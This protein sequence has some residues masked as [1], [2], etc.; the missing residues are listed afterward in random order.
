M[1]EKMTK[2]GRSVNSGR[3]SLTKKLD[4]RNL[5]QNCSSVNMLRILAYGIDFF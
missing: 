3:R 1:S 2:F 4:E 5:G